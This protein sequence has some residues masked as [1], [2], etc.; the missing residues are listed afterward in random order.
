MDLADVALDLAA[1]RRLSQAAR[2]PVRRGRIMEAKTL[3]IDEFGLVD[4]R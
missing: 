3:W 4:D 2:D 1:V